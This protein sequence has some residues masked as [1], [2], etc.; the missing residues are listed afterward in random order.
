[1]LRTALSLCAEASRRRRAPALKTKRPFEPLNNVLLNGLQRLFLEQSQSLYSF[2]LSRV[3]IPPVDNQPFERGTN[4][5]HLDS[6][7]GPRLP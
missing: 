5:I 2:S 1:M 3:C 7:I 6:E 4:A